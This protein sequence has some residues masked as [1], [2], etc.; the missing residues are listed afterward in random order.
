MFGTSLAF[1]KIGKNQYLFI[2]G[3][4]YTS[5]AH[6]VTYKEKNSLQGIVDIWMGQI[7]I[8][9]SSA[10][11]SAIR[12]PK[13]AIG[14]FVVLNCVFYFYYKWQVKKIIGDRKKVPC[15]KQTFM[16]HNKRIEETMTWK[17]LLHL[18]FSVFI[19]LATAVFYF[20]EYKKTDLIL[21]LIGGVVCILASCIVIFL[22]AVQSYL[23]LK[24]RT[25]TI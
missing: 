9:T 22:V 12:L 25:Q 5:K 10:A 2:P 21:N 13:L 19:V 20:F 24:K 18:I 7:V 15:E 11:I 8:A 4:I 14:I 6:L 23:K 3:W 1:R 16:G 17:D